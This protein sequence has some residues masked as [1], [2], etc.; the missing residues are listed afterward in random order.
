MASLIERI[1][2]H[3]LK[4]GPK[5]NTTDLGLIF[6][7][8]NG[9]PPG[10]K[11]EASTNILK[12]SSGGNPYQAFPSDPVVESV[13][14]TKAMGAG[15]NKKILLCDCTSALVTLDL[16]DPAVVGS[17]YSFVAID[18]E[19]NASLSNYIRLQRNG[20]ELIGNVAADFF[21]Y[22]AAGFVEVVT[23]GTDWFILRRGNC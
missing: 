1:V 3:V 21:I 6:D 15:D 20:S 23:D 10:F 8:G 4:I 19:M 9:S 16:P 12:F 11:V 14:G 13:T 18:K 22:E 17:G 2:A 7:N 5:S